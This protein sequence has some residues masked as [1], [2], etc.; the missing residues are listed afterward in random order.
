MKPGKIVLLAVGAIFLVMLGLNYAEQASSYADFET[1]RRTGKKVHIVGE[2]V[3]RDQ[4]HYD[5]QRDEFSFY[6]QDSTHQVEQVK[7]FDPKPSNFEQAEK[8]VVV[9]GYEGEQFI[10]DEIVMKCP[11]KYE[12]NDL[13]AK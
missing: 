3:N 9:G 4:I 8:V 6:L 7:Y 13:S 10:A 2:W 11:S 5:L 12:E 1:A